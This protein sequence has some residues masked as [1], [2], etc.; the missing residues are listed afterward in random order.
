VRPR[1]PARRLARRAASRFAALRIRDKIALLPLVAGVGFAVVLAVAAGLGVATQDH[2]ARLE[3][4]RYPALET[5]RRLRDLLEATQGALLDAVTAGDA[6]RLATADSL[7]RVFD[8]TLAA[9]G[10]AAPAALAERAAA[11]RAFGAYYA[12]AR[13][14]AAAMLA[15]GD[16]AGA[17]ARPA[18]EEMVGRYNAMRA[19][20]G[21]RVAR[22]ARATEAEFRTTRALQTA[23]WA[24]VVLATGAALSALAALA[25]L[26]ARHIVRPLREAAAAAGRLAAGDVA[27]AFP[28]AGRD[29]VG[30]LL[31]ALRAMVAHLRSAERDAREREARFR[32]LVHRSSDVIFVVGPEADVRYASPSVLALVGLAPEAVVGTAYAG[33]VHPDDAAATLAAF[34]DV[35]GRPGAAA[36]HAYRVRHA[37]GAWRHVETVGTN[38]LDDPA[39]GGVV[40]NTRDVT[41]RTELEA[42]LAH[43]A[44]HDPLT[45]LANR[46]LFR[47]R[48]EH[49]LAALARAGAPPGGAAGPGV[50]VLFLDLDN[51]K[52]VN[53]SLGHDAGDRLLRAA[54]A[55]LLA[56]TRGCDTVARFGGDEFAVLLERVHDEA[57]ALVVAERI[58]AAMRAPVA[59]GAGGVEREAHVG[60]SVGVAFAE[61][62]IAA[63][64]LLRNADAAMYRAKADGK[65]RYAVFDPAL[66]AAAAERMRLEADLAH[67]L[68]AGE[69]AVAYQPI[70]TLGSG[71][72]VSAEALL[73]WRHPERGPVS[74]ARFIPL[75][76]ESGLIV[77][78]GRWVLFEACRA[79]A[80]WPAR[81]GGGAVGVGVNVSGRQ[82]QD[83]AFP[84]EVRA[85]LAESGLAPGRLTLEITESTIMRD[86]EATLAQLHA[87]KALGVRLAIDDFGTGYS[88]LAYL[89]RF[90]VDVLKIDKAFVD[91]IAR[92]GQDAALARTVIALGD[93]L[94]LRTVAEGVEDEAQR[95]RLAA[96]GCELGQGYLFARPLDDAGLRAAL[97]AA[98]ARP[99]AA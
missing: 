20:L 24:G 36:R 47:D 6:D 8:A 66:V 87:L 46:A 1:T 11:A 59:V 27:V 95:A 16:A 74:P 41:E 75:A 98:P 49:A 86:T 55:R 89:Q 40:L 53:D 65:G 48:V 88:S 29:E 32:A 78:L 17:D 9:D 68:A 10:A 12:S 77:E 19:S 28:A 3:R 57:D 67:A 45:G 14:A 37:D 51:F 90:P 38:L 13:R 7:R 84:G 4:E 23:M 5:G 15:P 62:A 2:L 76:E 60:A 54:S 50:A 34:R 33:L 91:G 70:V 81:P 39:V 26:T 96:M 64:E 42:R 25:L 43:Q 21:A 22:D 56:A 93:T 52:T 99:A 72:V 69:F 35:L 71:E 79:A 94:S 30:Q 73:R 61:P 44:F 85:A 58:A 31:R 97:A 92:G 63:D 18:I 83:A 82:L 80:A